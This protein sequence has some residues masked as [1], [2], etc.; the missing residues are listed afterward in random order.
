MPDLFDPL[1]G[2]PDQLVRPALPADEVRR[3]G[4][5]M[6]RRRTVAA[7]TGAGLA[8]ALVV[9]GGLALG[10]GLTNGAGPSPLP[11]ATQAPSGTP[12]PSPGPE[13]GWRTSI[14]A[15]FP[16]ADD[17]EDLVSSSEEELAGPGRDVRVFDVP[18]EACGRSTDLGAPVD[19]L[20]VRHTAPEWFDGRVLQVYGDD[21]A[22]RGVLEELVGLYDACPK[23]RFEG[24]PDT[25]AVST[26]RPVPHGEEGYLVTRTFSVDGP[27][28]PG[29]ELLHVVRTG[30]A[31][32]VSN[33]S[34][35]GGAT[36]ANVA[37]QLGE[38]DPLVEDVA[39]AMCVFAE[40]G[41]DADG[42]DGGS[43]AAAVLGLDQLRDLTRGLSTSWTVVEEQRP[44]LSCQPVP[45]STLEPR[46]AAYTFFDGTGPDGTVNAQAAG[47]V[48]ELPDVALA[49]QAFATASGWLRD[50]GDAGPGA[51][52]V[53][54]AH[55]PVTQRT[56]WGPAT[57]R[58]VERPAPE[59]CT[60]C[61]TGWIDA[62]GVVL[63]GNRLALVSLAWTG[64]LGSGA[65]AAGSPMND[66]VETAA[67]LAA[68]S[69]PTSEGPAF[70]PRGLGPVHLGMSAADVESSGAVLEDSH[71]VGCTTFTAAP[72][73]D[74]VLGFLTENQGVSVLLVDAEGILTP[75]GVGIGATEERV[76]EAYPDAED[77]PMG[78]FAP[79]PGFTDRQ[80]TFAFED[81]RLVE[82]A[83]RLDRQSCVG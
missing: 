26:V 3:R 67:R 31:L 23:D 25:V 5:R 63:V 10:R 43:L 51:R 12:E 53:A 68:G 30:N 66:A 1:R 16:L 83:L 22:A 52:P 54:I 9:S 42:G 64:D 75:A 41:C 14:P 18:F 37:L 76:R 2:T 19:T 11:P 17:L 49:E 79:V 82:M 21:A 33:L 7:A 13:V 58:V 39:T 81:G 48:L 73:G 40:N 4:D 55:D 80:Y 60:E 24:P 78:L 72:E 56:G 57:W 20:A 65:D 29:L 70:G 45:L 44:T 34:N 69:A 47:A 36:D 6:R 38:R 8:V 50:C 77:V 62:Q 59:I 32:L 74:P 46:E 61:D 35:E 15:G 28:V 27:R 71:G